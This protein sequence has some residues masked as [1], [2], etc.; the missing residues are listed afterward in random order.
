MLT[1]AI[2]GMTDFPQEF[3]PPS[4][5]LMGAGPSSVHPR[6][7]QAMTMPIVGHLDPVFF[8]CMDDVCSMLRTV[9]QTSNKLTIPMS[10]TGTGGMEAALCNVLERGDSA[11]IAVNGFFGMRLAD[12]ATRCGAQ[13]HTVDFPLGRPVT[14][15]E[16]A[17]EMGKHSRVKLL[18][19]VHAETSTGVISPL[20]ELADIARRHDALLAVDAVTSLGGEE[21]AVDDWDIDICYG[22]TQ[23]C[24]G[25]P[26]GLA[27]ITIGPR[28]MQVMR[29]R[30]TKVQSFYLSLAE[31]EEYWST[32][33]RVYHHTAPISM[34]YAI[35]E[36]LRMVMEEGLTNRFDRHA[37]CASALRAGLEGLGLR[38]FADRGHRLNS[39]TTVVVPDGIDEGSVRK[40]LLDEH[41]IEIAGGLGDTKGRLWRI[42]LMGHSCWETNVFALLSALER[43]LSSMGHKVDP[44]ASLTAA[45][46]TLLS[47]DYSSA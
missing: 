36:A 14:P 13:V 20:S 45:Q 40:R 7:L 10:T 2:I 43:I 4:R 46:K 26:P 31:L 25:A 27:P 33:Q 42:G 22:A 47:Y 30:E 23:K 1:E 8:Q 39:L 21:V 37:R 24:L 9:F 35:W 17:E 19:V 44:G 41:N 5:I 12:I 16:V 18:A 34:V 29:Q 38:L 6:V 3:K 11:V 15:D 28:S 32:N